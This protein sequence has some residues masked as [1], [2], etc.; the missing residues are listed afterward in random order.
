MADTR[1]TN[2]LPSPP[3]AVSDDLWLVVSFRAIQLDVQIQTLLDWDTGWSA[4]DRTLVNRDW[5]H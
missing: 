3:V 4:I 1:T 5:C 2:S